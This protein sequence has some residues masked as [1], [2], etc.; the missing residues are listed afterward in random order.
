MKKFKN[1]F[2]SEISRPIPELTAEGIWIGAGFFV[3]WEKVKSVKYIERLGLPYLKLQI[4][5]DEILA[6][7]KPE[8]PL[9]YRK[10]E[11]IVEEAQK[12]CPRDHS[13]CKSLPRNIPNKPYRYLYYFYQFLFMIFSFALVFVCMWFFSPR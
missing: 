13:F 2:L 1:K 9:F 4:D 12:F 5:T 7:K 11:N 3:E 10:F 8:I 6:P